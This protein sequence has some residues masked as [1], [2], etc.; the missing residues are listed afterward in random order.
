MAD[1]FSLWRRPEIKLVLRQLKTMLI[2]PLAPVPS[3]IV[4]V[5]LDDQLCTIKVYAKFFGLYMDLATGDGPDSV[6]NGVICENLNRIV[7]DDYLGFSGDFC[8]I[9]NQGSSD[10]VYTGL[11]PTAS[12]RYVLAYLSVDDLNSLGLTG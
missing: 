1:Q 12:A 8:F 10:P 11:G 6:I 7:R 2:V 5:T 4:L 9:D 3:Q